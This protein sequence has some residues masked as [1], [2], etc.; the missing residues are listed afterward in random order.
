MAIAYILRKAKLEDRAAIAVLIAESARGLSQHDY[1][2]LQIEA[3]IASVFGVDTNLI[4]DETYYVAELDGKLI[5]C[6][7][8]SR[9]KTLFG[10]DQFSNR[11]AG[12]LDPESE[13]AKIRAFFVHPEHARKGIGRA[14]L[15]ACENEAS[16][17]G[18]RC[19]ELM[20]TLP[21]IPL[22]QAC[23]Y[24]GAEEFELELGDGVKLGLLPMTKD[25]GKG[26]VLAG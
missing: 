6:G 9:R 10:G 2:A 21:G 3:A 1:S 4:L 13:A 24:Q 11:D 15:L 12:E 5:G 26:D 16:N 8:W 19:V 22:Y 23:G 14:L 25:L 18:F 7:G 17:F 20:A